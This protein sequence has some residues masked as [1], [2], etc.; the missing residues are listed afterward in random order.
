MKKIQRF[1]QTHFV[2]RMQ[3]NK[4]VIITLN[5]FQDVFEEIVS[6]NSPVFIQ[7]PS[8]ELKDDNFTS[9]EV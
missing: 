6:E 1:N 2:S 3:N 7:D 9:D 4:T 8:L 5:K